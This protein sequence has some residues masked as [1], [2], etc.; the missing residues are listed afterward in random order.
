MKKNYLLGTVALAI[1]TMFVSCSK[2]T[3]LYD[4]NAVEEG[5]IQMFEMEVAQKK[6]AYNEA[7]TKEFGAIAPGH[8][9]GFGS[10]V[11]RAVI[12]H[13]DGINGFFKLP[14]NAEFEKQF[15]N[16]NNNKY[17]VGVW[18]IFYQAWLNN[19]AGNAINANM[20]KANLN[21]LANGQPYKKAN[22]DKFEV[23]TSYLTL[24]DLVAELGGLDS[25]Y[26]EHVYKNVIGG[27]EHKDF[28]QLQAYNYGNEAWE[29]VTNFVGGKA[30]TT[31]INSQNLALKGYILM[32]GM[33]NVVADKPLLQWNF[34]KKNGNVPTEYFCSDYKILKIE[35]EYYI[36]LNDPA[37]R[38]TGNT[39][40]N[41]EGANYCSWILRIVKAEP[42]KELIPEKK[43][44]RVFCEDMGEI[45][46][47]DFNDLVFDGE[48]K[49]NG[50]IAITVLAAGGIYDYQIDGQDV[51]LG[52]MTNTG[53]ND[54]DC[55]V[56]TIIRKSN[57]VP[58]YSNL[59]DIPI[60]VF[61][62]GKSAAEYHYTLSAGEDKSAPQ[63]FCTYVGIDWPDEYVNI[64]QAYP[65]FKDWVNKY[66]PIEWGDQAESRFVDLDLT[67]NK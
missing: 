5:K 34:A 9:W 46:D 45:G 54:D 39:Q 64:I 60:T 44:G 63:K 16:G 28:G 59:R 47:F 49:D 50:D 20:T 7:F 37:S 48:I 30:T 6:A 8:D 3:D 41:Y 27:T 11:T 15:N 21:G 24:A 14:Q 36:G 13:E 67:N 19:K 56:I 22:K 35:G 53:V 29:N 26:L 2:D 10:A 31:F 52:K 57:G 42:T 4:A 33:G 1:G 43:Q 62:N 18:C 38:T 32:A 12:S 17:G 40:E 51:T 61:P 58:K 66:N 23:S 55:Q 65:K 25:Y